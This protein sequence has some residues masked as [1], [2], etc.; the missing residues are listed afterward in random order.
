MLPYNHLGVSN[1]TFHLK[2]LLKKFLWHHM[3][4]HLVVETS[5]SAPQEIVTTDFVGIR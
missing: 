5:E 3:G 1:F 2:F 4:C